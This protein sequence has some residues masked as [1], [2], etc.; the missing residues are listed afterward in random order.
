MGASKLGLIVNPLAGIG[1]RV[2][3]KGSDGAEIQERALELGAEPQASSRAA[4]ALEQLR[5]VPDLDLITY[6]GEMGENAARASGFEP[7]VIG[8]IASGATT[9]QDTVEAAREMQRAGIDLLLFAGGDGTARDIYRAIGE[10]LPALGIPA[11]VKIH[12]AVYATNPASAGSLAALYL[13]GRVTSLQE[14]EVMDINEEAFRA[15][16]VSA[17][18]YG[19]LKIPFL[20]SLVQS[21]KTASIGGSGSLTAIAEDVVERMEA[22]C[23]YIVG[24]GTTTRAIAVELGLEK[25][26]LGVDVFQAS[27]SDARG[28]RGGRLVK[29]DANET[30]LLELLD[31]DGQAKIIVTLIGGQ[32][33]IFGRGNQQISPRVIQAAGASLSSGDGTIRPWENIVVVGTKDK[34]SALGSKPLRV[35]TG[36][37]AL[38]E[39]LSGYVTVVTGYHER[40]VRKVSA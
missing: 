9:A 20:T 22:G 14:A 33:F 21:Q 17:K 7:T 10:E 40:A 32:G 35:D 39:A 6:P 19:Y 34:L 31:G 25:T 23:L 11:G 26:L 2:G 28:D 5:S 4:Q 37:P 38:D 15:G 36:D 16:T 8:R 3:L 24:P 30:E 1:G 12:S 27:R 29:A 13:Q 18:L